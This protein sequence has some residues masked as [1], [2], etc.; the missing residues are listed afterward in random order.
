MDKKFKTGSI[1]GILI[2]ATTTV[3]AVD[4]TSDISFELEKILDATNNSSLTT[5]EGYFEAYLNSIKDVADWSTQTGNYFP[6]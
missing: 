5:V 2:D 4:N 1:T 6:Y 3:P